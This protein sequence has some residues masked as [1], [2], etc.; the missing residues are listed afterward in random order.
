MTNKFELCSFLGGKC[1]KNQFFWGAQ[2]QVYVDFCVKADK[3][4]NFAPKFR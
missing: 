1:C 3:K 4:F 2:R